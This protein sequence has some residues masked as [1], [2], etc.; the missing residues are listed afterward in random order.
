MDPLADAFQYSSSSLDKSSI[1]SMVRKHNQRTEEQLQQQGL[2]Q[3]ST[4]SGSTATPV[5][6]VQEILN[7]KLRPVWKDFKVNA[8]AVNHK[9][10]TLAESK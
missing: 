2:G 10:P 1:A 9:K 4:A 6:K 5:N 3:H 8:V 7:I